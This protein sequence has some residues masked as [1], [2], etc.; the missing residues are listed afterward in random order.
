MIDTFDMAEKQL[1]LTE[2][3]A[4]TKPKLLELG[5]S[6]NI[7]MKGLSKAEMLNKIIGESDREAELIEAEIG[8]ESGRTSPQHHS[9][10]KSNFNDNWQF[11]L[12][13]K[14]LELE[15]KR[16]LHEQE[17]ARIN[18]GQRINSGINSQRVDIFRVENAT[19]LLP[20]L[21]SENEID[22]YLVTFEKIALLQ[23]W[24][25]NQWASVLQTQ[26]RGKGL[27]VFAE[28]SL[29]DCADYDTFKQALLTAYELCS[30]V[31]RKRFRSVSKTSNDTYADLAFKLSNTFKRWLQSVKAYDNVELLRE[32]IIM[33][34]FLNTLPNDLKLWLV[35]Q[36][37]KTVDEMA[38]AAD[39]YTAVRKAVSQ[40][41]ETHFV[42][43]QPSQN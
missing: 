29:A 20:K 4:M 21:V 36:K 33:E 12:E 7:S 26:L 14:K 22:T 5:E 41:E 28:L 3:R 24:P 39:Q 35:D 10:V 8:K 25:K 37:C 2:L 19:K 11:Q 27:K 16:M 18:A 30:E 13:M 32:L 15:E 23:K 6:L 1:T 34:Q 43:S 38:R 17:M 40:G 42:S 9:P 31:Y